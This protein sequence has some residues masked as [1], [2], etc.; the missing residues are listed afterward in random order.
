VSE[1]ITCPVSP[2]LRV[3]APL[4]NDRQGPE[5]RRKRQPAVTR[6]EIE[7]ETGAEEEDP[8]ALDTE[9]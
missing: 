9:G 4:R 2:A 3:E 7:A 6:D 8:H 1:S 5:S